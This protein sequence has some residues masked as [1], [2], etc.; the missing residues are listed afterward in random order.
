MRA[1]ALD[2]TVILRDIT[3]RKRAEDVLKTFATKLEH[4]NRELQ[5]FASVA[6]HDLQEPMRMIGS[7]TQLLQR[8]NEHTLDDEQRQLAE[9]AKSSGETLLNLI[10]DIL[11]FSKIE[12]GK[13]EL[14]VVAFD[15]RKLIDNTVSILTDSSRRKQ[16]ELLSFVDPKVP[17]LLNGDPGRLQG[18]QVPLLEDVP[19]RVDVH[20]RVGSE[21]LEPPGVEVPQEGGSGTGHGPSSS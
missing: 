14:E 20:F 19:D 5:E 21:A 17:K 13:L 18:G 2:S 16:L 8:K 10:S 11:D 12:A 3:A 1:R 15:L 4:R 9:I 6:S 7:Y